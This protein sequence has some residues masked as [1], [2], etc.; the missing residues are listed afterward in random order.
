VPVEEAFDW[1]HGVI[2]K[3]ACLESE[4]TAATLGKEASGRSILWRIWIS[5]RSRSQVYPDEHRFRY[6]AEKGSL[7]FSVNYF[8]KD[9]EGRWLNERNDKKVWYEWMELR[10]HDDVNAIETPTG[11]IPLYD[12]LEILFRESLHKDY[13]EAEY[14]KQFTIRIPENLA[15]IERV[16]K[17]YETQVADTPAILF[18]GA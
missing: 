2:A 17:F 16:K 14:N 5:S 18:G 11:F 12:D 6:W 4:T 1:I 10:V 7:I 13:S 8:L 15:K 3:G 9:K